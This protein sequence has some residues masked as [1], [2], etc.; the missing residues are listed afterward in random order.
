MFWTLGQYGFVLENFRYGKGAW[1]LRSHYSNIVHQ[2]WCFG[3]N[4][5]RTVPTVTHA[6]IENLPKRWGGGREREPGKSII[7]RDGKSDSQISLHRSSQL[8]GG[9]GHYR[10]C[11]TMVDRTDLAVPDIS[12]YR[13]EGGGKNQLTC[14]G[15]LSTTRFNRSPAFIHQ[16]G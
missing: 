12:T 15:G 9:F 6:G 10:G 1:S 5:T 2:H 8:G 7:A 11:Q 4:S 16:S 14:H 3:Y 13:A